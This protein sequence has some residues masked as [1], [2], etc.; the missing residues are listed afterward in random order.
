MKTRILGSVLALILT[1]LFL[2]SEAAH[3]S[4]PGC[5]QDWKLTSSKFP[6]LET[7]ELTS[8]QQ[9][10]GRTLS[11]QLVSVSYAL[12]GKNFKTVPLSVLIPNVLD[13]TP[14]ELAVDRS[15][16]LLMSGKPMKVTYAFHVSGCPQ[17]SNISLAGK[18]QLVKIVKTSFPE[19]LKSIKSYTD[20][21]NPGG[22]PELAIFK[23]PSLISSAANEISKCKAKILSAAHSSG[24]K[25]SKLSKAFSDSCLLAGGKWSGIRLLQQGSNCLVRMDDP[26]QGDA[27]AIKRGTSCRVAFARTLGDDPNNTKL[28]GPKITYVLSEFTISG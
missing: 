17:I 3:A 22:P 11:T 6:I 26:G 15:L 5:P 27:Y 9:S 24:G 16:G 14:V 19:Y 13:A 25:G 8:I 12:D 2:P 7:D 4:T 18:Y 10:L 28:I 20:A 1:F 21:L 23:S